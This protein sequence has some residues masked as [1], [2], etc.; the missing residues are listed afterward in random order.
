MTDVAMPAAM[1]VTA[2]MRRGDGVRSGDRDA[3]REA[4][5]EAVEIRADARQRKT[6]SDDVKADV[7]RST[8]DHDAARTSF[9]LEKALAAMAG[10]F[11]ADEEGDDTPPVPDAS[12]DAEPM[13]EAPTP[14]IEAAP[15]LVTAHPAI[16][17]PAADISATAEPIEIEATLPSAQ[18]NAAPTTRSAIVGSSATAA[19]AIAAERPAPRTDM[20]RRSDTAQP[21]TPRADTDARSTLAK[22]VSVDSA[23][24]EPTPAK[25]AASAEPVARAEPEAD[26]PDAPMTPRVTVVAS[27]T[28]AAPAPMPGALPGPA[29]QLAAAMTAD[30]AGQARAVEAPQAPVE[31]AQQ[32]AA[33]MHTLT[34]Q[35]QPV[36]L[37]R[38]TA[39]MMLVDGQLT[40]AIAVETQDAQTRLSR[41]SDMLAGALRQAGYEVD[42]VIVQ[43]AQQPAA[44]GTGTGP[45]RGG[46]GAETGSGGA[47]EDGTPRERSDRDPQSPT[48]RPS[49][50]DGGD[51]GPRGGVYI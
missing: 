47:R 1:Q 2:P 44:S 40:V 31:P 12:A 45:E 7:R 3:A 46:H 41:D 29:Q 32:R 14:E 4:F 39:R 33:P 8:A 28:V 49:R 48:A 17:A 35:L 23:P 37:G 36:E 30:L 27:Q 15:S 9:N 16:E 24:V 11:A 21:Q 43:Q 22:T 18:D 34:I 20:A 26:R 5:T 19:A 50:P 42:R 38:V 51:D 10:R 25:P 6:A 13:L